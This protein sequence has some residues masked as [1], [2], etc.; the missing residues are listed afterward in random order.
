[1]STAGERLYDLSLIEEMSGGDEDFMKEM[2]ETFISSVPPVV[3]SM[4]HYSKTQEW[5]KMG[6]DAHHLK[7]NIDTLQIAS[8]RE[9]IRTIERNGKNLIDLDITPAL[10]MKVAQVLYTTMDQIK[11]QYNI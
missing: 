3:D 11:K 1:M 5:L 2:A 4:I 7:S 8:I 10:V 6:D 9:D